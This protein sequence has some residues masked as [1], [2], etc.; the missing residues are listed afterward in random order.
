MRIIHFST[1]LKGGAGLA[2]LRLCSAQNKMQNHESIVMSSDDGSPSWKHSRSRS[3]LSAKKKILTGLQMALPRKEYEILTP[4]SISDVNQARIEEFNPDIIHIHNWYNLLS[5][6]DLESLLSKY[7]TVF[8]MHDERLI[9]GG[10]HI[11]FGCELF[12]SGCN[13][14]PQLRIG[15][16]LV[17][18]SKTRLNQILGQKKFSVITP[19]I[20]LKQK[21]LTSSEGFPESA[22]R[23]IPN[24][25]PMPPLLE[26]RAIDESY[27]RLLFVAANPNNPNKGLKTVF[28]AI[29]VFKCINP[30]VNI[31]LTVIGKAETEFTSSS[32][33]FEAL[34]LQELP[35]ASVFE[36]MLSQDALL[37]ASKSEN[38]P[39]VIGEAQLRRLFVIAPKVGGI[40]ELV[41]DGVTGLLYNLDVNSLVSAITKFLNLN[42][43]RK[44][45]MRENALR[46]A[47]EKFN[48]SRILL[49]TEELYQAT[50]NRFQL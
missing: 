43:M 39:N 4:F 26:P 44:S 24:I 47:Q 16:H 5:L 32:R 33:G 31:T 1:S 2:A 13:Q 15:S 11:T 8:T 48:E 35:S 21:F 29:E 46:Q 23:V 19:S 9:S 18:T 17:K 14:C 3:M 45:E 22:A 12:R 7:P 37:L 30:E 38:S 36:E 40:E 10:C 41:E 34:Y 25:I 50:I 42:Q 20:W 49:E 27:L 28:R 6:D